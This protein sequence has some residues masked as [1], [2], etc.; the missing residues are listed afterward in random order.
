M[1]HT[2]FV[3]VLF[4]NDINTYSMARAFHEAYG[5]PSVVIGKANRG[6][7]CHSRIIDFRHVPLLDEEEVFLAVV[8]KLAEENPRVPLLLLGCGDNYVT[9]LSRLKEQLPASA[10]IP[11]VDF[12]LL[13]KLIRKEEFYKLCERFHILF[14]KTF[15]HRKEMGEDYTLPFPFPVIAKP[16]D[17][18]AYWRHP[19]P[20]Q[21]KVYKADTREEL[22]GILRDIYG[23]G[24]DGSLILQEFIPG[25]DSLM[26]V[27]TC[28]SDR[29]GKV[30]AMALGHV[31]LE[32]HTPHGLGNHA[33][34]LTDYDGPLM[35]QLQAFLEGIGYVGFSNFD[36]K[37]DRRDGT[38]RVFELNA[39]QGRSN[40]YVTASGC[41]LA[42]C[43]ADDRVYGKELPSVRVRNKMLWLVIPR[44]VIFT[45]VKSRELRAEAKTLIAE[46]KAINP[47]FYRKDFTP[48][49][50][51][52]LLKSH[53]SHFA[54]YK[55][56]YDTRIQ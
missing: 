30:K 46:G 32:E 36:I 33:A 28:Y 37:Y 19:F 17:G 54:K 2:D 53:I 9:L 8:Q 18:V 39:R 14:P 26:R 56:Y 44:R 42:R 40:F 51:L 27:L 21:K 6:P 10:I 35:D 52:S 13:E 38:Y 1:A 22:D 43:V 16:S 15:V 24:Y 12:P 29:A 50:W 23:A 5:I 4:G 55:R 34:I 3:P 7:S 41:N 11:Y 49:R 20:S 25:D 45:Y 47:L 48:L 31:L